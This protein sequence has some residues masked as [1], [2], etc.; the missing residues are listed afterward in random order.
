MLITDRSYT[1]LLFGVNHAV[2]QAA[3]VILRQGEGD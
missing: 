1:T 2:H 3:G